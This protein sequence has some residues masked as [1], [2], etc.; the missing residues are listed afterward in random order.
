MPM[1]QQVAKAPREAPIA[2]DF[3]NAPAVAAALGLL[4]WRED[5]SVLFPRKR[6][7]SS[8]F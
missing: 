3:G 4:Y 8:E 1:E 6:K 5:I 7:R 2:H